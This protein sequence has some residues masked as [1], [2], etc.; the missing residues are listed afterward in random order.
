MHWT[1]TLNGFYFCCIIFIWLNAFTV[2]L[3]IEI[4]EINSIFIANFYEIKSFRNQNQLWKILLSILNSLQ[5]QFLIILCSL[6]I[7][8]ANITRKCRDAKNSQVCISTSIRSVFCSIEK[9]SE[10]IFLRPRRP[11]II[12]FSSIT[13]SVLERK[14]FQ[15]FNLL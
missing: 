9:T 4:F 10:L 12:F 14:Y 8:I 2:L 5:Y 6:K 1:C 15:K 3:L 13:S 7:N 11:K